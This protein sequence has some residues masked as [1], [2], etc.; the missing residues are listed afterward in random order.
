MVRRTREV[1]SVTK[2]MTL[3]RRAGA[4]GGSKKLVPRPSCPDGRASWMPGAD[5]AIEQ[6][7]ATGRSSGWRPAPRGAVSRARGRGSSEEAAR[8]FQHLATRGDGH[9]EVLR[10]FS[11]SDL[12]RRLRG[13]RDVIGRA[14]SFD[15]LVARVAV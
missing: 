13:W 8:K 11:R 15:W 14:G 9:V 3:R 1:P 4:L 7:R 5:R 2:V 12:E 10:R 6:W